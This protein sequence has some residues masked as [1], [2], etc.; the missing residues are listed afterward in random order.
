MKIGYSERCWDNYIRGPLHTVP[1]GN[2]ILCLQVSEGD[3]QPIYLR[4]IATL[5]GKLYAVFV[6]RFARSWESSLESL[7]NALTLEGSPDKRQAIRRRCFPRGWFFPGLNGRCTLLACRGKRSGSWISSL[8]SFGYH[9]WVD[10]LGAIKI[11]WAWSVSSFCRKWGKML[12]GGKA[13]K[14]WSVQSRVKASITRA[15]GTGP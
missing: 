3:P 12:N 4:M 15:C 2:P 10:Q 8:V 14:K 5:R 1:R 11:A 9:G 13:Y 6:S 7:V